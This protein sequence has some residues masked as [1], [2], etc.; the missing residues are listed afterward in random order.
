MICHANLWSIWKARNNTIFAN[1]S[2]NSKEV[3]E[4]IKVLSW[5][6]SLARLKVLSC[7]FYKWTWDSEECLSR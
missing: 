2:F 3:V 5:K 4:E 1:D 7:L 6:W